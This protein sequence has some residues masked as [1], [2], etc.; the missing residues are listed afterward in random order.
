MIRSAMLIGGFVGLASP[1]REWQE[2]GSGRKAGQLLAAG[3][4]GLADVPVIYGIGLSGAQIVSE[5]SVG[6][7]KNLGQS[8]LVVCA[9]FHERVT[10]RRIASWCA[11]EPLL[12][13][14]ERISSFRA[15][16]RFCELPPVVLESFVETWRKAGVR[17]EILALLPREATADQWDELVEHA[18]RLRNSMPQPGL[19]LVDLNRE[20][21]VSW[22]L[23]RRLVGDSAA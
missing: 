9:P 18:S 7:G 21:N 4:S 6:A 17:V 2:L 11:A 15:V 8:H 20:S 10:K 1:W 19:E 22:L 16:V 5:F 12:A 3:V 14:A 13:I 23:M